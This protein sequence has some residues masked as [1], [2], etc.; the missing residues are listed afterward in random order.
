[1]LHSMCNLF[2]VVADVLLASALI[3][4]NERGRHHAEV[5]ELYANE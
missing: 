3:R 5:R 2:H 4:E 1:M